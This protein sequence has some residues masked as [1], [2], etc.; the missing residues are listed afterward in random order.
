MAKR[1]NPNHV[2]RSTSNSEDTPAPVNS[3]MVHMNTMAKCPASVATQAPPPPP[4]FQAIMQIHPIF[5]HPTTAPAV[6]LGS[7]TMNG[8]PNINQNFMPLDN[9]QPGRGVMPPPIP[10][11]G[12]MHQPPPP[13]GFIHKSPKRDPY[14]NPEGVSNIYIR[15]LHPAVTD[16]LLAEICAP[17]GRIKSVK[18]ILEDD[19]AE[20]FI[21]PWSGRKRGA[22]IDVSEW[23][24]RKCKGSSFESAMRMIGFGD[25]VCDRLRILL[26]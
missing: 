10:P 26:F 16:Q 3:K 6:P 7:L 19:I 18:A 13:Q 12:F 8:N 4:Q 20:A 1:E 17:F 21:D 11:M 15:P 14:F 5:S 23:G 24:S 9:A 2:K 25:V 22:Q